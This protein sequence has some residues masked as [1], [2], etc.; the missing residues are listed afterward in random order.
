MHIVSEVKVSIPQFRKPNDDGEW[1]EQR[2]NVSLP[3]AGSR[4]AKI[5]ESERD[6]PSHEHMKVGSG[7]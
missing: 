1:L 2:R 7:E 3:V 6:V 5:T 4:W